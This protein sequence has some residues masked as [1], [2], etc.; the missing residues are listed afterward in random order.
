MC[1]AC[2]PHGVAHATEASQMHHQWQPS[3]PRLTSLLHTTIKTFKVLQP[4]ANAASQ[5]LI[6][7]GKLTKLVCILDHHA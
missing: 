3:Q 4:A 2:Q 1:V 7:P 6:T 5:M